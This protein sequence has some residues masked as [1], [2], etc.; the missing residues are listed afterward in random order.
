MQKQRQ[1]LK[2]ED[3]D[4]ASQRKLSFTGAKVEKN[5]QKPVVSIECFQRN[6]SQRYRV[7][8]KDF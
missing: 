7:L 8:P 3:T 6:G 4:T 2:T 1:K 5:F